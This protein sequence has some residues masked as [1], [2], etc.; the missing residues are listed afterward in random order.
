[1]GDGHSLLYNF[2]SLHLSAVHILAKSQEK[3]G[4]QIEID[5]VG[6]HRLLA[7][8]PIMACMGRK[9]ARS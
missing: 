8:I 6:L 1:M 4:I 3:E 2:Q 9:R 7:D 5:G